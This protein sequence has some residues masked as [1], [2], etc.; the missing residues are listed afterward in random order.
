MQVTHAKEAAPL[1]CNSAM[2]LGR[3]RFLIPHPNS[4]FPLSIRA[5]L[6]KPD[7]KL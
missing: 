5:P 2:I 1:T 3:R 4:P 6:Q 7:Q